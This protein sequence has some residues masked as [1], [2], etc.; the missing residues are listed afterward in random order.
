M[1]HILRP[2][3]PQ[4]RAS[5]TQSRAPSC[6]DEYSDCSDPGDS[7]PPRPPLVRPPSA[8]EQAITES[9][10]FVLSV[11]SFE[12]LQTEVTKMTRAVVVDWLLRVTLRV[13]FQHST[14][15]NAIRFLDGVLAMERVRK[16]QIHLLSAVCLWITAKVEETAFYH[17]LP[18]MGAICQN[19]EFTER[20]LR[21]EEAHIV[22]LMKDPFS[23]PNAHLL[24]HLLVLDIGIPEA[25][26]N[27]E[28]W[29]LCSLYEQWLIEIPASLTVGAAVMAAVG[30]HGPF[31]KI[32]ALVP[33]TRDRAQVGGIL[34]SF[35][36]V[37]RAMLHQ[38]EKA[39]REYFGAD[40]I[41]QQLD[42]IQETIREVAGSD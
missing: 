15:F 31:E 25:K 22:A 38:P 32:A 16:A 7:E 9:D 17:S 18:V 20:E 14:L 34:R 27:A 39:L 5:A 36:A 24:L 28:F 33:I 26:E 29:L 30:P 4:R 41:K 11:A 37:A 8:L 6:D 13:K 21:L 42:V 19:S 3:G 35:A 23:F 12:R 2:S 1:L 10:S 40:Y